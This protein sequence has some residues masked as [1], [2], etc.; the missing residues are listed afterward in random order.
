MMRWR[1][2]QMESWVI[3]DLNASEL[4]QFVALFRRN[5]S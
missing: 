4:T 5:P 3:S 2:G 1:S